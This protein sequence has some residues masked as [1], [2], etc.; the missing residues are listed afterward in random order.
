[1]MNSSK[2]I[3]WV[4]VIALVLFICCICIITLGFG[5]GFYYLLSASGDN[6]FESIINLSPTTTPEVIRPTA[7]VEKSISPHVEALNPIP[8]NTL[9]E[10]NNTLVPENNLPE[11][12]KRL[13]GK[14][15]VPL[16]VEPPSEPFVEGSQKEFW[17]TNVDTNESFRIS[18]TLQ[19]LTEHA[20]FWIEDGVKFKI[21]DLSI[22]AET[23]ENQIYPNNREF[24]GSEWTP[25]VDGDPHL[26]ILY[27]SGLGYS[28]AGYFSSADEYHPLAHEYSN[29]HEMFLLNSDTIG[30]DEDFTYGV[31]AHEF[32]HMI[33]W[34]RDR[35]E[36]SWLNEGFAELA[37]FINGYDVGGFDW[38]YANNPDLQ[39]ND[40][41]NDPNATSPHYGAAF[42]FVNYF[43]SRFGEAATQALVAH[44]M[45]GMD[46][47]DAVLSQIGEIDSITN[48]PIIADDV[49][50]DWAIT[51]YLHDEK[52]GDGRYIYSNYSDA[53]QADTTEILR[54]CD[55]GVQTRDVHQYGVDYISIQCKGNYVLR[56][57]GSMQVAVIPE[58]PYSGKFAFWSNKG[59]ESDM[60][61]T[62]SFDFS[63]YEGPLTL[64]YWTWYDIEEDYDY[65]YV[66]AAIDGENWQ[67]LTTPSGTPDDPSGNSYGWGYNGTSPGWIMESIDLTEYAGQEVQLRFEYIT[68][69]AVNGEGILLDDVAIP[70]IGYYSDFE[71]DDGG[72][73][74]A[75]W[76]RIEN[77]L[78]Q[79]YK[80]AV[81]RL[82]ETDSVEYIELSKEN[83]IDIPLQIGADVKEVVLIVAGTTRYTRQTAPYRFELLRIE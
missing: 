20:Y 26:Y 13:Q 15:N 74:S 66:E 18:A 67:I 77:I 53:P 33:H 42:L 78:P 39:V 11:L 58:D 76:V 43:L 34:Y 55:Q 50:I 1:M 52:I 27:A 79:M 62:K 83:D 69:A 65:V 14:P 81:I 61:L 71:S 19:Y 7:V 75:G 12:A 24:F 41:P 4:V 17:V 70:E 56:F 31:L 82:G 54:R 40:W 3:V 9:E 22:L 2:P 32:Q 45:N 80:L 23:F 8:V 51:N 10:L 44:P 72:W 73:E 60:T 30:L 64:T 28:L 6:N 46:S 35:N 47:V 59:D 68:D 36:N 57:E 63:T 5:A 37:A 49:F 38:L 25:G 29:A 21:D 16:T 48:E